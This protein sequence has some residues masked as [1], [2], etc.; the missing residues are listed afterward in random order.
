MK[1]KMILPLLTLCSVLFST[2]AFSQASSDKPSNKWEVIY[3]QDGIVISTRMDNCRIGKAKFPSQY[4]FLKIENNNEESK[5]VN[6]DFGLQ[7]Y[8]GCSG[9]QEESEF[10]YA[11]SITGNSFLEADCNFENYG[12]SRIVSNPNLDGG[13]KYESLKITNVQID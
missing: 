11:I 10:H 1:F 12:L 8:E 9:C 3:Q 7:Y 2:I 4:V 6:Y 13:W 5:T